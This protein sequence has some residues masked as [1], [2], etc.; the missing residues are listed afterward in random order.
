MLKF[1]KGNSL[2]LLALL[3]IWPSFLFVSSA[4]GKQAAALLL[5]SYSSILLLKNDI[6]KLDSTSFFILIYFLY[7]I[8]I[9]IYN[10]TDLRDIGD[11]I[12]T[13]GILVFYQLGKIGIL[14]SQRNINYY[15]IFLFFL[16]LSF[17]LLPNNV[18]LNF[19]LYSDF[20]RRFFG[21]MN[22]PNYYWIIPIALLI[23][24]KINQDKL[25]NFQIAI[26][27][28]SIILTGSRTVYI[29]FIIYVIIKNLNFKKF[30]YS[31]ILVVFI[32][33]IFTT[34]KDELL[35]YFPIKRIY[36]LIQ[37]LSTFD[38]SEIESFK[39]R[40]DLWSSLDLNNNFLGQGSSKINVTNI[41]FDNSY[42][43]TLIRYGYVGIIIEF[44]ILISL[45]FSV[46]KT[47]SNVKIEFFALL[48]IYLVSCITTSALYNLKLPYIYFYLFGYLKTF[49][50]KHVR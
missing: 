18:D 36:L 41:I 21:T 3:L 24:L 8:V 6:K 7:I 49:N 22:S 9:N 35:Q 20:G 27:F 2:N 34:F 44:L 5:I 4:T 13:L 37:A 42:I 10:W 19:W 16:I 38:L 50:Q 14:M 40:L 48:I 39:N 47:R 17:L 25:N 32:S 1:K 11:I 23:N 33:L 28:L 46:I 12:R 31:F 26:L 29:L 43:T 45:S 30:I 15:I